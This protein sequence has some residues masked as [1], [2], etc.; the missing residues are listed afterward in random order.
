MF[1]GSQQHDSQEFL[2]FLMDGLHEDMNRVV[3]R[4]YIENPDYSKFEDRKAASVAWSLH[5]KRN[6]SIIVDLFQG[7]FRSTLRCLTCQHRSVN[8]EAFMYLSVPLPPGNTPCS[9]KETIRLFTKEEHVSGSD[10]WYC[11]T[12]H[13]HRDASKRI[14][15][16]KLPPI[17]LIH[18]KRF[19]VL[20]TLCLRSHIFKFTHNMDTSSNSSS[21]SYKSQGMWTPL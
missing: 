17:L 10:K 19:V 18:L 12:C 1:S 5:K 8:F 21:I 2:A 20:C 15:I 7:Q 11:S 14:E 4:R 16:W 6:D 9:L 13:Q 3:E